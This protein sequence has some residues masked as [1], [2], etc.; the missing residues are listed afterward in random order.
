MGSRLSIAFGRRYITPLLGSTLLVL[1]AGPNV[2]LGDKPSETGLRHRVDALESQV[3]ALIENQPSGQCEE[4]TFVV[5]Y[6]P[7]G[8]MICGCAGLDAGRGVRFFYLDEDADGYGHDSPNAPRA[9]QQPEGYIDIGGDCDDAETAVNPAQEDFFA[10]PRENGSY[11]YNC[12]GW[13]ELDHPASVDFS[14]GPAVDCKT[15]RIPNPYGAGT[16]AVGCHP[17]SI[18]RGS[19]GLP[20]KDTCGSK[21]TWGTCFVAGGEHA[22]CPGCCLLKKETGYRGCR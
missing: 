18:M 16:I 10:T 4:G 13:E 22:Y 14:R 7:D 6:D 2:S 3:D 15:E 20:A 1:A 8:S 12:D 5:G 17:D 11:D 9:C 21:Y 19:R